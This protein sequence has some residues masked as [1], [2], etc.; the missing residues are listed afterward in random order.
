M[1]NGRVSDALRKKI[2][3]TYD[4]LIV[5]VSEAEYKYAKETYINPYRS[6]PIPKKKQ[7]NYL[8]EY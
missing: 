6:R 5:A 4:N 3:E 1:A 2:I 8:P 7:K